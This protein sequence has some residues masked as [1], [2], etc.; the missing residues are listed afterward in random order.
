MGHVVPERMFWAQT[1]TDDDDEALEAKGAEG[2]NNAAA[3][4][5]FDDKDPV[6]TMIRAHLIDVPHSGTKH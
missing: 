5:P 3:T 2:D 4:T 6:K 1:D